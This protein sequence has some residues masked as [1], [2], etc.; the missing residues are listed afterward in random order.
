[1]HTYSKVTIRALNTSK[2]VRIGSDIKPAIKDA[3][4]KKWQALIDNA[5]RIANV[6]AALIMRLKE[7]SIEV[8]LKSDTP[9]NPYKKGE[10]KKLVYGIYCE[11]VIGTQ[12]KLHVPDAAKSKTWKSDNPDVDMGMISYLGF[13]VNWPEG[14]VFG[15]ICLL[16]NKENEYSTEYTDMLF[17]L[18]QHIETDLHVLVGNSELEHK[19]AELERLN[20][21]KSRF[22]SLIS[23]DI[24]GNIGTLD[25]FLKLALENLENYDTNKLKQILQSLSQNAAYSFL[26]LENLLN[27]SKNDLMQLQPNPTKVDAVEILEGIIEYF[28]QI[29]SVKNL[30]IIK[31]FYSEKAWVTADENM[32]TVSLRNIVSNAIKFTGSGGKIFIRIYRQD[33]SHTIEV[34][35]TGAGMDKKTVNNLFIH[36]NIGNKGTRGEESAGI[37]LMITKEFLDKNNASVNVESEPGKGTLFSVR[38]K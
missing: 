6:P 33:N 2:D 16:D 21:T 1:M 20:H 7:D 13:P 12:E 25:E 29:I 32:F 31:Q 23:H 19:N 27:W 4:V 24:R 3:V 30:K 34:E 14:E 17:L 38:L 11:T 37:G 35:D 8:F 9:G 15:T 26:T 18:K 22:L 36:P 28:R 10:E 5:A